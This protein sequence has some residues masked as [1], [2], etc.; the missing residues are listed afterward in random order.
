[1]RR[2]VL[3]DDELTFAPQVGM[4]PVRERV[5]RDCPPP[6]ELHRWLARADV[7][8]LVIVDGTPI[9]VADLQQG[10]FVPPTGDRHAPDG[11]AR[12]SDQLG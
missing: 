12:R 6:S 5:G 8:R 9:Q 1:M 3:Y 10:T 2:D 11:P 7:E 4:L